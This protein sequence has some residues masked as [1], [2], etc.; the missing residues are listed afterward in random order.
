MAGTPVKPRPGNLPAELTSF[1]GRRRE[2]SEVKRL[3]A[4][5]RLLTLT[6][7]GGAGKT[8]LALRA[9]AEV[10]RSFP[11]GVWL[12][13][14]ASID[15]PELVVQA[16]F[17]ALGLQDTSGGWSLSTLCRYLEG[18]HLLL[19]LDNCEHLLDG[20]A[21]LAVTVL[22]SCPELQVLATSRQGLG[23]TGE[24]RMRV[25]PLSLPEDGASLT[26][27][28]I[29]TYEAVS[30]LSE[31]AAAVLPGFRVDRA[32]AAAVLRLCRR[33]DGMPLALELAAVRLE[34]LT[35][36]QV[37]HGLESELPVLA[38]GSRGAEARQRTLDATIGWSYGLLEEE[39]WLLWARLSVFTGGFDEAA[40]VAVC[41]GRDLPPVHVAMH[42]ASLVEKSIIQRDS[43]RRPARYSML[44][45]VRRYGRQ[46]LRDLGQEVGSQRRHCDWI[47][48]LA[49][50]VA[51]L[52][53]RQLETFDRVQ[54][55]LDNVWS[56][57]DFCRRQPG[58]AA[59]G[60]HICRLLYSYWWSRGPLGDVRR[61]LDELYPLTAENSVHRGWCSVTTALLAGVQND[62]DVARSA[63]AEGLR[64]GRQHEH[65]ALTTWASAVALMTSV[66]FHVDSGMRAEEL[67]ATAEKLISYSRSGDRWD[68]VAIGLDHVCKIHLSLGEL[69]AAAEAGE[70]ALELCR[71]HEELFMSGYILN[72]LSE[73]RWRQGHLDQAE[74]LAREG[75]A[76]QHALGAKRALALLVETLAAMAS[77]RGADARAATL[78]GY[79]QGVRD[80]IMLALPAFYEGRHQACERAARG[81]LG[82]AGF[83]RAFERGATMPDGEAIAY[84]LEQA[85]AAPAVAPPP[86][87]K[88]RP[89]GSLTRR[90]LEIA[91]LIAEGLT[92]HQIAARLFISERTVTTHVTNMLNKLGLSS[93]IQLAGWVAGDGNRPAP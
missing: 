26:P 67:L 89:A 44:E 66:D 93:R 58:E 4:R 49:R 38:K 62:A 76:G 5:A 11:D 71:Q 65:A 72:S 41:S 23:T 1:V 70:A 63:A 22:R 46:R 77:E 81:R 19:V 37:V 34:G 55:E 29:A 83:N 36:D 32:N 85:P 40:A 78:L 51:A 80:S 18:R 90:E 64:I 91:H 47:L 43:S 17:S 82:D 86:P 50:A 3:L 25:P 27:E 7:S 68:G 56:A 45:T 60:V 20:C 16:V 75:A 92:S 52:D 84:V 87:A 48:Q 14:L 54:L 73:V 8:R 69:E 42:L 2:L 35:V 6:G 28:Q 61:T 39:E 31:R 24:T 21:L 74:A 53:H 88:S 30:L 59:A 13:S 9:A 15:D 33:L 10:A 79:A 57:L 12:V